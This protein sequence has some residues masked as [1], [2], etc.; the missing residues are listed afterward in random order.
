MAT[1]LATDDELRQFLNDEDID[2][3]RAELL[4]GLASGLVRRYT[5]QLFDEVT[6]EALTLD[7]N[8]TPVL[9]LPELPVNDVAS[10]VEDPR[11]DALALADDTDF[12]WSEKGILTRL[13]GCW[14][15]RARWYVVTYSH[16]YAEIPGDV[17]GVVLRVAARGI[18]NPEGVRQETLGS[19]SYSYG[20][21][22]A[23]GIVLFGPDMRE[24]GS[25]RP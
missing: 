12:E 21:S 25:Y 14:R 19:Y 9:L 15:R 2:T 10:V 22:D 24:L 6:D 1:L 16:G 11:G 23:V 3:D 8:G 20:G 17:K 7:G 4:L 13:S 18:T 5:G